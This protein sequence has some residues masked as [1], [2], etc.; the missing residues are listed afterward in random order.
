MHLDELLARRRMIRH[1]LPDPVDPRL[2]E[3][4]LDRARRGPSAGFSQGQAFVVV[5]DPARRSEL[6]R[7][8][9]ED[10]YVERG[11]PPWLSVAPVHVIVCTQPSAYERRYAEADKAAP[12][13]PAQWRV[14]FWWVDAGSA[15]MLLLL[16][17]V[18]EG[19]GAGLL[20]LRRPEQ[21]KAL[22][23]IPADV[24]PLGLVTLGYPH[25]DQPVTASARR[26]RRSFEEIVR[27]DAW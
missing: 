1:Y 14:P 27:F 4:I 10:A 21:V 8:C 13:R 18:E 6:A 12:Q 7:L 23:G 15:L 17:A 3:R 5:T 20:D 19:L 11:F 22:L 2:L 16:A 26:G 9:D 24:H 25:P